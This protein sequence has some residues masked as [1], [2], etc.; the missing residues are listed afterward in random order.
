MQPLGFVD[1]NEHDTVGS[2]YTSVFGVE[3]PEEHEYAYRMPLNCHCG[4]ECVRVITMAH[5]L[6]SVCDPH[7]NVVEPILRGVRVAIS[8]IICG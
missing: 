6:L 8:I 7:P 2:Y 1:H 5:A 4:I 3:M